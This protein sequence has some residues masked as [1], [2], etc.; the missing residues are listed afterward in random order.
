MS[1]VLKLLS[2][3][4]V[5]FPVLVVGGAVRDLFLRKSFKDLDLLIPKEN[6]SQHLSELS[7][8]L[9]T[10]PFPLHEEH[11]IWRYQS[12]H[13]AVDVSALAGT[14]AEDLS[15]RD[16]TVNA[17]AMTLPD[18]A[19][20]NLEGIIDYHGGLKHLSERQLVLTHSEAIAHD[21]IRILRAGRMMAELGFTPED[22]LTE[23]AKAW[24]MLLQSHPGERIWAELKRLTIAPSTATAYT[25]F[26]QLGILAALFPELAA[27]KGVQQNQYHSYCVYEHSWKAFLNY[28]D[29]WKSPS[30][31]AANL[32]GLLLQELAELPEEVEAVCKL[33]ALLHDIG[34]PLSRAYRHD[35]KVTFYRHQQIGVEL[36]PQIAGRLRLSTAE[37]RL[38]A[39]F[40]R[41]HNYLARLAHFPNLHEGH[42]YR[43]AHRLG[44]YSAPLALFS[45]ADA[46]AKG[47]GMQ[48]NEGYSEVRMLLN[49][50]LSAW[51]F[52]REEVIYPRLPLSPEALAKEMGLTPGRWLGETIVYLEEQA[53]RGQ[54]KNKEQMV[55]LAA[56]YTGRMWN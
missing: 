12:E 45:I 34:K 37:A 49:S 35:G 30:F 7:K 23:Q 26:Y 39:R 31:L 11:N 1:V 53:A 50:F 15:R 41:W 21:P 8:I 36:L 9:G 3:S 2:L 27:G 29:I 40:V 20:V 16:F 55:L 25:W 33:G 38:L 43:I 22:K 44:Q 32:Q 5:S 4:S 6:F 24:G 28:L 18:F 46:L 48:H 47:E 56:K 19:A 42:L 17:M 54:I 14:L 52:R 10:Q 13:V 51:Y